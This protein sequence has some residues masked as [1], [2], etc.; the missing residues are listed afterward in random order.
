M[1][2]KKTFIVVAVVAV[3]AVVVGL[4]AC[5]PRANTSTVGNPTPT[6]QKAD[7]SPTPDK[8][9]VVKA[10]QWADAYPQIFASYLENASNT[11]PASDYLNTADDAWCAEGAT[12]EDTTSALPEGFEYVDCDKMDYL[13]TNPEIK[14]LGKGYGY[15]KY[16]TEPASHVYSLWSVSHNGRVNDGTKTK[17]ACITCKTPQY[18][19]LV[20]KEGAEVHARPFNEVIAQLDENISCASCH[21]NTPMGDDGKVYLEVDRAEWVRSMGADH[22]VASIQGQICG[23]CHCDYSMAPE[24]SIPTSPYD[25]GRVDMVP[26]KALQWYDDHGFVDWTYASTGAKMLAIRHAEYEFVYGGDDKVLPQGSHMQNLGYDC[27]DCH[28]A[29]TKADDGTVYS[30]HNWTSP[31]DNQELIDRDCSSCHKDLVAEVKAWQEDIDGQTKTLGERCEKFIQ[32]FE[33]KVATM[34]DD[35]ANPGQQALM[36]DEK[37]AE[38]NGIDAKTLER[39][40][41]I[42]RASCYYWN[43]DAAENSEG[44]HNPTYYRYVLDKGN[45]L[46]DE[47]DKLL[48]VSSVASA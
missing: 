48:G 30:N 40:Q 23:Q 3:V 17:A 15:A 18:S 35:P 45:E 21:A 44:A 27:N 24:T 12:K 9:G 4:A 22:E 26:D 34:Q 39:L 46:L 28:M 19:N 25:N 8:F 16:Y 29:T 20:D 7:V 37:A 1:K 10:I 2:K 31:L 42:Q 36:L 38:K 32:N 43:L 14:T 47:G 5:A 6:V 13:E 11:P 33:A 41:W